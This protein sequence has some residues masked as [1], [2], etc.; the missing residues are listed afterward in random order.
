[1]FLAAE[2]YAHAHS[3]S[4]MSLLVNKGFK[5]EFQVKNSP[6]NIRIVLALCAAECSFTVTVEHL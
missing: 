3:V 1:M 2:E 5:P 4:L 6:K